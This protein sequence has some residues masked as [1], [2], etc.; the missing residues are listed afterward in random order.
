MKEKVVEAEEKDKGNASLVPTKTNDQ[1]KNV[2]YIQRTG[3]VS[4]WPFWKSAFLSFGPIYLRHSHVFSPYFPNAWKHT[5][6]PHIF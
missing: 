4:I 5:Q 2:L 1:E 6:T 3:E